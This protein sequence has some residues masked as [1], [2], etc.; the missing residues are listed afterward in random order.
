MF[1][2]LYEIIKPKVDTEIEENYVS[3]DDLPI[4]EEPHEDEDASNPDLKGE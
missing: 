2:R 1:D 3:V 4:T